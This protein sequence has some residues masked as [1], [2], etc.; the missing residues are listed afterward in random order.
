MKKM[1]EGGGK[2]ERERERERERGREEGG[3]RR[4]KKKKEGSKTRCG[5]WNGE[6]NKLIS[7]ILYAAL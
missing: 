6:Q 7:V 3:G 5:V 4:G 2:R 1:R